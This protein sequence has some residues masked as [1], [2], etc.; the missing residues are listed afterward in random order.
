MDVTLMT[1]GMSFAAFKILLRQRRRPIQKKYL[2]KPYFLKRSSSNRKFDKTG[3]AGSISSFSRDDELKTDDRSE[4]PSVS[5]YGCGKPSIMKPSCQ[6]CKNP[7]YK[8]SAN[9]SNIS[10]HSCYSNPNQSVELK[11]DVKSTWRNACADSGASVTFVGEVSYLL[12][13]RERVNFQKSRLFMSL[14]DGPK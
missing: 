8:D 11:L 3:L 6:N 13:R 5:C 14:A 4:R 9:F 1:N 10:L 2:F 7:A 12:L